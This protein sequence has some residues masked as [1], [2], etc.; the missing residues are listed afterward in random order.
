M[1]LSVWSDMNLL[2][3]LLHSRH[4]FA[5][6]RANQHSIKLI[7]RL[8]FCAAFFIS[9]PRESSATSFVDKSARRS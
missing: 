7:S 8:R 3:G 2:L 6:N 1:M 4:F 5:A 9:G